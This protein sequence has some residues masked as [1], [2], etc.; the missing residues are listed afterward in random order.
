M[1][2]KKSPL[3]PQKQKKF[4]KIEGVKVSSLCCGLKKNNK[5]DL[6]L[7]TFDR[8]SEIFGAFTKSKTPGEPII[9]NKSIMKYGK[10]SAILINSGNANVFNGN[11]GKI[12]VKKILKFLSFKLKIDEKEIFLASTGVIGEPLDYK[13]II[14]KIPRLINQLKNNSSSWKKAAS[15]ITTTDTY[16]KMHSEKINISESEKIHINGI[17]KGSGMIAPNMA[18]MLSFIFT[19]ANLNLSNFKNIF[20]DLVEKTF[21]SI[22]VDSDTSTS[23]MVLFTFVKGS[24]SKIQNDKNLKQEF[25]VKSEKL[26]RELAHLIVKDGEGASKFISIKVGG[27]KTIKE[28]KSIGMT[29]ANSPLFKTA[30]TGSDSNWGRIIMALG[31]SANNLNPKQISIKFGDYYILE[32]GEVLLKNINKIDKYLK[33]NEID[34][35][36]KV[37]K[38]TKES[39]VWTCDL[40]KEYIRIN[41]DYRS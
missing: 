35:F 12:A 40:T 36:I 8:K 30:M 26:M 7:I 15:A 17:A 37:G 11:Q 6:V 27:V 34:I 18:T 14:K 25:L 13:K 5:E 16:S 23:D 2:Y 32:N 21:N 38:G 19:D 31:K 9:W 33:K 39:T 22:T 24:I 4:Y 29:V 3:A 41:S 10:V 1:K 20:L 28:A